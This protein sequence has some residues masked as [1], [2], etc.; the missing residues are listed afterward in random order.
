M[1]WKASKNGVNAKISWHR[2]PSCQLLKC[3]DEAVPISLYFSAVF[4]K[5]LTYWV[6]PQDVG[7]HVLNEGNPSRYC[8]PSPIIG[9]R[10]LC[11][12]YFHYEINSDFTVCRA[13][14]KT[15][16]KIMKAIRKEA[17]QQTHAS[18][19]YGIVTAHCP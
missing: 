2:I 7:V 1:L 19:M 3:V 14:E 18:F 12:S 15:D 16:L 11:V 9:L 17:N 6:S 4:S 5:K 13:K 10:R 8:C